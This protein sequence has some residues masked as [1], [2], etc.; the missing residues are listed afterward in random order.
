VIRKHFK[1]GL[2]NMD[3]G[4][5]VKEKLLSTEM[6]FKRRGARTSRLLTVR[7]EVIR[8]NMGATQTILEKMENNMLQW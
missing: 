5:Q 1:I 8:E 3:T 4:L 7:N 2:G 6:D